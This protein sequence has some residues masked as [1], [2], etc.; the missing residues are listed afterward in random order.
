MQKKLLFAL[1]FA[2]AAFAGQA[3]QKTDAAK[4]STMTV[5]KKKFKSGPASRL[6][7]NRSKK[8]KS[9][10]T[11]KFTPPVVVRDEQPAVKPKKG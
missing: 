7:T 5:H 4:T 10:E 8:V 1:F 9:S 2:F 3:Q 6:T 11:V